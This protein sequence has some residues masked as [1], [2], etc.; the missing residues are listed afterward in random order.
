M[1]AL[2][3]DLIWNAP[4]TCYDVNFAEK[5][6]YHICWCV[7]LNYSSAKCKKKVVTE[8]VKRLQLKNHATKKLDNYNCNR[9]NIICL[10]QNT[11]CKSSTIF[12]EKPWHNNRENTVAQ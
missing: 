11:V 9:K 1:G 4:K 12:R 6:K 8:M 2:L 7:W 3:K 10:S 5:Q